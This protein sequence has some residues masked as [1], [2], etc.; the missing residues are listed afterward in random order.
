MALL[1]VALVVNGSRPGVAPRRVAAWTL[2]IALALLSHVSTFATLAFTLAVMAGLF[3]WLG[4]PALRG[5]A[6][7]VLV[8]TTVAAVFSVAIYYGH[9]GEVYVNAL[10]V[11]GT[12]AAVAARPPQPESGT[13]RPTAPP[14]MSA[15][16]STACAPRP[17]SPARSVSRS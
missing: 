8:A 17:S 3:W 6:R 1:A 12:A 13:A 16:D 5:A 11:R 2:V 7:G 10:K 14:P 15:G 4:G 9:F